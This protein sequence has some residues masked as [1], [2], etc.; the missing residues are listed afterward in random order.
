MYLG[1]RCLGF[2]GLVEGLM[3]KGLVDLGGLEVG[4]RAQ[5]TLSKFVRFFLFFYDIVFFF[6]Y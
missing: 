1:V 6:N 2:C 4:M 5:T 3:V